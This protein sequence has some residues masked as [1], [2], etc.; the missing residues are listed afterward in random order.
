[1]AGWIKADLAVGKKT[2]AQ[3]DQA[4]DDLGVPLDQRVTPADLRSDEHRLVDSQ[5]PVARPKE[6]RIA[7]ADPG[8][9][10]PPMTK[11][12][13]QF[14]TRASNQAP[15]RRPTGELWAS[16]SGSDESMGQNWK[17]S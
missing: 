2:Q 3:A 8:Q 6:I 11:E 1:M 10:A 9:A 12:V 13:Q 14:D 16:T 15:E 5:F 7:Y 17:T 4:F